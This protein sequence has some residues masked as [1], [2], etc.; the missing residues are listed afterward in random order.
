MSSERE[1]NELK[2][3][4][5]I[6]AARDPNSAVTGDDAA[7]VILDESKKAGSAA[8]RFDPDASPEEKAA[9]AKSVR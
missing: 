4:G 3:E 9:Q 2:S 1:K 7:R 8:L 5:A 6:E